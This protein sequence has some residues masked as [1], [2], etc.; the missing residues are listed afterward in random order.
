MAKLILHIGMPK[1]GS[2]AIQSSLAAASGNGFIYPMLGEPPFKPR[3]TDTLL[4][5]FSSNLETAATKKEYLGKIL[6]SS[7]DDADRIRRAAAEAGN[8][9]VI[10]SSEGAYSFLGPEDLLSLRRFAERLFESVTV[11]AY[12]REPYSFISSNIQNKI[13]SGRLS[14]FQVKFPHYRHFEKFDHVFG[15]ANVHLWEYD[16]DAFPNGS[17]VEDFCYKL[18]IEAAASQELNVSLSRPAISAIYR[19]N[20]IVRNNRDSLRAFRIARAAI[21][22]DYP[23]QD[24]PKF[25]L[26]PNLVERLIDANAAEMDW[27]EQRMGCSLRVG[28]EPLKTDVE[29]ETELLHIRKRPIRLIKQIGRTLP[30]RARRF[31]KRALAPAT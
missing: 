30:L 9:L 4:R 27:I 5:L 21:I 8:G 6:N 1:T 14:Q 20:R 19:L 25:R 2:S 24:W 18:G 28:P 15:R 29:S 3:H 12:V 22:S 16:R 10:L 17:I 13:K 26:S 23:H 11:V 7:D 31:L